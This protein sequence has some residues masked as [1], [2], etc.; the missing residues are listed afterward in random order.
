LRRQDGESC[1]RGGNDRARVGHRI[2]GAW[3]IGSYNR[4]MEQSQRTYCHHEQ[5]TAKPVKQVR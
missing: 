4:G 2:I 1:M 3:S 5:P